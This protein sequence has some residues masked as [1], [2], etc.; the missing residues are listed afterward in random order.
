M[1]ST[2]RVKNGRHGIARGYLADRPR[3]RTKTSWR[4]VSPAPEARP[5]IAQEKPR[6]G[7][8]L[9]KTQRIGVK[10]Q[11]A[12]ELPLHATCLQQSGDRLRIA[13]DRYLP[14]PLKP[15]AP[16]TS[17]RPAST[18]PSPGTAASHKRPARPAGNPP[19]GSRTRKA[20]PPPERPGSHVPAP[21][22]PL[23]ASPSGSPPVRSMNASCHFPHQ[24]HVS[25]ITQ[26]QSRNLPV[27]FED[28]EPPMRLRTLGLQIS[29]LGIILIWKRL[30]SGQANF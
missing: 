3:K 20:R 17:P 18:R 1:R 9:G 13:K 16:A 2:N 10:P 4:S 25:P 23:F 7:A 21:T 12:I 26:S 27:W 19:S 29:G 22:H 8:L 15:P 24:R 28:E 5:I 11:R 30:K 6:R 14:D